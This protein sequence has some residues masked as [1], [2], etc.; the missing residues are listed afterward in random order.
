MNYKSTDYKVFQPIFGNGFTRKRESLRM[1]K[2]KYISEMKIP[3]HK[4]QSN[5]LRLRHNSF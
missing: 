3:I 1:G 4:T 5:L 2:N